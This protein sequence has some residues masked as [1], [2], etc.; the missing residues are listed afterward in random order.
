MACTPWTAPWVLNTYFASRL[1]HLHAVHTF[2][3]QVVTL[4]D[5]LRTAQEDC[6]SASDAAQQSAVEKES[7]VRKV[8]ALKSGLRAVQDKRDLLDRE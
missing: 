6:A 3:D 8:T 5:E 4:E 1:A 7:L 2:L